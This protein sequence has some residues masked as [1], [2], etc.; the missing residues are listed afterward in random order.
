MKRALIGGLASVA[1]VAS[2]AAFA[3]DDEVKI[4]F[5]T[6]LEG[7]YTVPGQ[8]AQ[9]GYEM[10][11]KEHNGQ[12]GGKKITTVVAST[13]ASPD[14]AVR[15][16]RKLVE[17]DGVKV[18]IGPL[19]GSEGI[20]MRDFAH[21]HPDVTIINGISGAQETTMQDPAPNF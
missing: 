15:A 3:A 7:V 13:D 6:T 16:A 11:V 18:I 5:M 1:L 17:Q 12:V 9:R 20:A 4:G 10:A 2:S 21:Q 19:S 14:S 8:D